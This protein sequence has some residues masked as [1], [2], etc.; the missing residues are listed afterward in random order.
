MRRLASLGSRYGS[1][2][3]RVWVGPVAEVLPERVVA[4]GLQ[5]VFLVTD[6]GVRAA[7]HPGKAV[8][9]L[10]AL[11]VAVS[12][13][14]GTA[15]H[16]STAMVARAAEAARTFRPDGLVAVGGGSVLDTAKG[17][18][19]CLAHPG[20]LE[21]W[22][23]FDQ[24]RVPLLPLVAVPTTAGTGSEVQS[25]ALL[26]H[27]QDGTK[28]A[29]GAS[30]AMPR[31]AVLDPRLS[32]SAPHRVAVLAAI[33]ALVH[34]VETYVTTVATEDSRAHA[35]AA[36]AY[37]VPALTA[38]AEGRSN[39]GDH[40]ALLVGACMA[41]QAIEASMLGAAHALAN[42][43]SARFGLDHGQAVGMTATSVVR[44]NAAMPEVDAAY[45]R[46]AS[47]VGWGTSGAALA[48]G[49]DALFARAGLSRDLAVL[50]AAPP[51]GLVDAALAQWTGTFNPRGLDAEGVA[52]LYADVWRAR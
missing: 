11:G 49:L 27:A 40:E 46:L 31:D 48:D 42:P 3:A 30:E 23:G 24:V 14:D 37:M 32:A 4:L 25:F 12:V 17:V 19:M 38:L 29:C 28:M 47:D 7:G 18:A 34:A 16:P 1:V 6:A 15:P 21:D 44:F 43:L 39:E 41:G 26:S 8:E 2:P 5:R 36:F 45:A 22:E 10:R 20:P 9:T 52:S 51:E 13:Y 33:D 50:A 35:R